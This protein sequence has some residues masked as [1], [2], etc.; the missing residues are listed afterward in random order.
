MNKSDKIDRD[1]V[2]GM[3]GCLLMVIALAMVVFFGSCDYS[4]DLGECRGLIDHDRKSDDLEYS[5]SIK[6]TIW[7]VL[8]SS[9]VFVPIIVVAEAYEC[10]TS[11]IQP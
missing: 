8:L 11:K 10:P 5:L 4:N 2:A 7:A 9:T 1:D 3:S 6:N